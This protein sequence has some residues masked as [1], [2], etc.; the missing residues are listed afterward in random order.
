MLGFFSGIILSIW[1]RKEGP[2]MPVYDWMVEDEEEIE[3]Q[4]DE[5]PK[6]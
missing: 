2:Q 4:R 3:E 1:F 5:I 6:G